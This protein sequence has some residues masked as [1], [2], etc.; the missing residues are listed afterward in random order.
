MGAYD[1]PRLPEGSID[2]A[3]TVLTYHHI[4][5]QVEYFNRLRHVLRAGG[6]VAHLDDRPDA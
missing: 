5:G 4:E 6:R 3:M 1:D 2:L